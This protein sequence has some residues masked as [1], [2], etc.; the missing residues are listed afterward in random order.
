TYANKDELYKSALEKSIAGNKNDAVT[1]PALLSLAAW[2][3]EKGRAYDPNVDTT[4]RYY[5]IKARELAQKVVAFSKSTAA[6]SESAALINEIDRKEITLK[7]EKVNVSKDPFRV[8]VSYRN[9][10][11]VYF[12]VIKLQDTQLGQESWDPKFWKR[13][14][15]LPAIKTYEYNLP[16][17]NDHQQHRVEVKIETLPLGEY[18]IVASSSKD[19]SL[20]KSQMALHRIHVSD[21]A[22]VNSA[23]K[24][25][26]LNRKTGA[27]L[28]KA[29]VQVYEQYYSNADRT[30]KF[31]RLDSYLTDRSGF[32]EL[33][34]MSPERQNGAQ[35]LEIT[36]GNDRLF[37]NDARTYYYDTNF[38]EGDTIQQQTFFF[39]DR[40]IYRP[41][42]TVYFK[43]ITV[44]KNLKNYSNSILASRKSKVYLTNANG[45]VVDSIAL[46]TNDFGSYSGR[47]TL[48]VGVLNGSFQI[49]DDE[50][51][52]T[53]AFNVEEYKRPKFYIETPPPSATYRVN[54]TVKVTGMALSYAGNNINGASVKYRVVR[55]WNMP[56]W[57]AGF[58]PRIWPPY[59]SR[60]QEIAHG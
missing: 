15:A 38:P 41:G 32:I 35:Y 25:Y 58:M 45:D 54:D 44:R 52:S 8:L 4:G 57:N 3:A 49:S 37:L 2:Y 39:T 20:E 21:I 53:V 16:P 51:K 40:S 17:T 19:F 26:V 24:Y 60:Q 29:K 11:T 22:Y 6:N 7:A 56:Y 43:G 36:Y 10:T 46:T 50:N 55:E 30:T 5:L 34:K 31:K 14:V 48:P 13:V 18:G 28:V 27:P 47:F 59:P 9:V 33:K 12:R 23:S 1:A 42:Q